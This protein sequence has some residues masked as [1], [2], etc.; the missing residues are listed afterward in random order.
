MDFRRISIAAIFSFLI[1]SCSG[2]NEKP[3]EN[4]PL[5][6]ED[7]LNFPDN[8]EALSFESNPTMKGWLNFY[9]KENAEMGMGNFELK[10]TEK[11]ETM[12]GSVNGSFDPEFDTVYNPFLVYNPSK[13]M[14]IDLD[15]YHWSPDKDGKPMF[16]ADQE[17]NLVSLN[18]KTVQRIGFYGPSHRAEDAFWMTDSVFVI[19]ENNDENKMGFQ[20]YNLMENTV[21]IYNSNEPLKTGEETYFEARL[22]KKGVEVRE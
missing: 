4:E 13:T 20:L 2:K 3:V 16:E 12:P 22:R 18:D 7:S 17:V 15:S 9:R 6:E 19:L 8:S 1:I 14:Y 21:S 10:D 11:L 5:I